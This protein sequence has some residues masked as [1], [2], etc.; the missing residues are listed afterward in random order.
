MTLRQR[1]ELLAFD[2]VAHHRRDVGVPRNDLQRL[3]VR[4]RLEPSKP[5]R[6]KSLRSMPRTRLSSSTSS[7][8][9][10]P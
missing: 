2:E 6:S 9:A 10:T 7:T 1:L 5:P 3:S 4:L 8:L